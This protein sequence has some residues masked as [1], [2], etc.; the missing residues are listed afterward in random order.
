MENFEGAERSDPVAETISHL[1]RHISDRDTLLSLLAAPLEALNILPPVFFRFSSNFYS[2]SASISADVSKHIPRIQGILLGHIAPVWLDPL[3]KDGFEQILYQYFCPD[4]FSSPVQTQITVQTALQAYLS[5]LPTKICPFQVELLRRLRSSYP[6]DRLH[7]ALFSNQDGKP[8]IPS[9]ILNSKNLVVWEDVVRCVVS[10]PAKVTNF[11]GGIATDPPSDFNPDNY[12]TQL[13][14]RVEIL[15]ANQRDADESE[16]FSVILMRILLNI[17][18]CLS[19][20]CDGHYATS[21]QRPLPGFVICG[22]FTVQ[23]PKNSS[24]SNTESGQERRCR[25]LFPDLA[26]HPLELVIHCPQQSSSLIP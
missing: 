15:I 4:V 22:F 10:V 14:Q 9:A 17:F 1:Q 12:F 13:S 8:G 2:N 18:S 25:F 23:F 24:F 7:A 6:L 5:I 19:V 11:Y 21:Q 3:R 20:Y 26:K 16:C